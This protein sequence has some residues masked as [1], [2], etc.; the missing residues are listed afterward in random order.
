MQFL[1]KLSHRNEHEIRNDLP[2]RISYV[3]ADNMSVAAGGYVD[4]GSLLE[5]VD[6]VAP[7]VVIPSSNSK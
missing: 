6:F 3:V 1:F 4:V 7:V 2:S 5:S